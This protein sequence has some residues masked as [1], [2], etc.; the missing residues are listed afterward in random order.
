M[1]K[2]YELV[3]ERIEYYGGRFFEALTPNVLNDPDFDMEKIVYQLLV[4]VIILGA[5]AWLV[6]WWADRKSAKNQLR[7]NRLIT[8][9]WK[10]IEEMESETHIQESALEVMLKRQEEQMRAASRMRSSGN[11][12]KERNVYGVNKN[13]LPTF[14]KG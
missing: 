10:T 11:G 12:K 6:I 9:S 7:E 14:F 5:F 8:F 1:E 13:S 4:G 2:V 3:L